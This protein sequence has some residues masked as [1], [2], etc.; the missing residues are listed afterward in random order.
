MYLPSWSLLSLT[1][2]IVIVDG[3]I[4]TESWS[5]GSYTHLISSIAARNCHLL[6]LQIFLILL[7]LLLTNPVDSMRLFREY[8]FETMGEVEAGD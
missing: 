3:W 6:P 2:R 7:P 4:Q 5:I 1:A 8:V